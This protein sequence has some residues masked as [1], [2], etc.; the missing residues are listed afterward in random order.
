MFAVLEQ[1]AT[2]GRLHVVFLYTIWRFTK[3]WLC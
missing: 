3:V 2:L 1:H